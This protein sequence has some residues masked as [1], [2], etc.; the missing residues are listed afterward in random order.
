M[1][2]RVIEAKTGAQVMPARKGVAIDERATTVSWVAHC[3]MDADLRTRHEEY[4]L[5]AER[6]VIE[7]VEVS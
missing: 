3:A 4:R 7:A 1:S 6:L 2:L 5:I